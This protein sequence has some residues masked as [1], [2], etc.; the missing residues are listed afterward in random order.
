MTATPHTTP[1]RPRAHISHP[2]MMMVLLRRTMEVPRL[3]PLGIDLH[4]GQKPKL[5]G[6]YTDVSLIDISYSVGAL[7][8]HISLS[9]ICSCLWC[10]FYQ[11]PK[12]PKIFSLFLYAFILVIRVVVLFCLFDFRVDIQK[13]PKIFS[14][15]FASSLLCFKIRK[16]QKYL[17]FFFGFVKFAAAFIISVTPLELGYHFILFKM[18]K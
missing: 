2:A 4:L 16:H 9:F 15:L 11:N 6:R 12:I 5:G 10:L 3:G 8:I 1:R 17:L 14:F 13:N 18:H 7:Y